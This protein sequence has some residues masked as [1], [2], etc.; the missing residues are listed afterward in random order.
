[1]TQYTD[2]SNV[3]DLFMDNVPYEKWAE[4]IT[5]I[6]RENGIEDGL[7][8]D[9]G[10]GTGTLTE[11]LYNAGY[12]MIG[13]DASEDMLAEAREKQYMSMTYDDGDLGGLEEAIEPGILY[14]CQD[15]TEFE[16]YGTV[17]AIVSTCDTLN[18]ITE[19][20]KLRSVFRLVNNY[21]EPDGVFIFDMNAPEKY[22]EVLAD[23]VFAEN[24]EDASFIW[25]NSYDRESRINEYALTLFI[26]DEETEL[27]EKTE[28]LHYQRAYDRDEIADILRESGFEI[29]KNY[30]QDLRMYYVV[31]VMEGKKVGNKGSVG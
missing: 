1:M 10:C 17:R 8:L 9:L 25:E 15:I 14:L 28:E 3:Y 11:L 20:E 30:E 12:D 22:E 31:K 2:F 5:V 13:I 23:N 18:Y 26:R 6:L 7:V 16:L 29:I 27:Y 19:P 4:D 21:I 24:R